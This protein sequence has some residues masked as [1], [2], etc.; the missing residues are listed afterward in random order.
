MMM[1]NILTI[2]L[3]FLSIGLFGQNSSFGIGVAS[4][5]LENSSGLYFTGNVR[6]QFTNTFGWQTEVGYAALE[7]DFN[8]FIRGTKAMTLKSAFT[9]KV[10]DGGGFSV[11]TILGGGF[12]K[13][14]IDVFGLLS[15]EL[16]LSARIGKNLVAGI[17]I[18][19]NFVTWSR[20]DYYTAGITLRFHM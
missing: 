14:N 13:D 7:G 15:G 18:S 5:N 8:S 17:P 1:K 10:Y 2:F 16:F 20:I 19:Y 4:M 6:T 3:L 11:E 9:A 12:F